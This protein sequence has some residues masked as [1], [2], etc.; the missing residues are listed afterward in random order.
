MDELLERLQGL[1]N[2]DQPS[3]QDEPMP[4]V[5]VKLTL[6]VRGERLRGSLISHNEYKKA[7]PK[8]YG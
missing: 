1:V 7:L 5:G 4:S 6:V 2:G 3:D 8:S